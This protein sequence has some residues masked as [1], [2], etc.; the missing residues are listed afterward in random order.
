MKNASPY[1]SNPESA[2]DG[3]IT[4]LIAHRG[5]AWTAGYLS[6]ELETLARRAGPEYLAELTA[7]LIGHANRAE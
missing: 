5:E 2:L 3:H 1:P 6:A 4:Q 7:R